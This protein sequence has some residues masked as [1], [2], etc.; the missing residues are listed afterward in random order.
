M[1]ST[2]TSTLNDNNMQ[3]GEPEEN[4]KIDK[5]PVNK[6]QGRQAETI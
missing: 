2:F 4:G 3:H 6:G 5:M 1:T